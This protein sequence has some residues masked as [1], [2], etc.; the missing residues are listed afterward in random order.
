MFLFLQNST[1][2][3][4][5]TK[6]STLLTL[7]LCQ[8]S[9]GEQSSPVKWPPAAHL[10]AQDRH[11]PLS[12]P[13]PVAGARGE[14]GQQL[15]GQGCCAQAIF[16]PP[17]LHPPAPLSSYDN[18]QA[19]A[20]QSEVGWSLQLR[21]FWVPCRIFFSRQELQEQ[22]F[23]QQRKTPTNQQPLWPHKINNFEYTSESTRQ[24]FK[25]LKFTNTKCWQK[26]C[27]LAYCKNK[28]LIYLREKL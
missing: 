14:A 2:P 6:S 10:L 7:P 5:A 24:L 17:S 8:H 28:L 13:C 15:G 18:L 3:T 22:N 19:D 26:K 4:G 27:I 11:L 12:L 9:Q 25:L 16:F 21:T 23:A 1:K 20:L